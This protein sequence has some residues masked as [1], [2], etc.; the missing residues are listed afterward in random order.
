MGQRRPPT[1]F[2]LALPETWEVV[3]RPPRDRVHITL[4]DA[5]VALAG[6]SCHLRK[7]DKAKHG[8]CLRARYLDVVGAVPSEATLTIGFYSIGTSNDPAAMLSELSDGDAPD[9]LELVELPAGVAVRRTGRQAGSQLVH[10]IYLPVP[11]TSDEVAFFGFSSPTVDREAQLRELFDGVGTGLSFTWSDQLSEQWE[12]PAGIDSG[13]TAALPT[14]GPAGGEPKV[15]VS[16][17]LRSAF[18]GWPGRF[19]PVA[20]LAVGLWVLAAAVYLGQAVAA[21]NDGAS[22]LA[23]WRASKAGFFAVFGVVGYLFDRPQGGGRLAVWAV[24]GLVWIFFAFTCPEVSL[25][26]EDDC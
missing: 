1:G 9:R 22:S 10:Q 2:E 24:A 11:G 26:G 5:P 3:E 16:A 17:V 8:T 4:G 13:T 25:Y 6:A 20:H 14:A 18:G 7:V 23:L 21:L 19:G 15:K 12:P